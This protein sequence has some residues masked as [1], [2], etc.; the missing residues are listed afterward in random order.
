QRVVGFL[1]RCRR[2]SSRAHPLVSSHVVFEQTLG[3]INTASFQR[4]GQAPVDLLYLRA[5]ERGQQRAPN[6][7]VIELNAK[8]RTAAA[9][10]LGHSKF[11]LV[12]IGACF[13]KEL[14]QEW[15]RFDVFGAKTRQ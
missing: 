11:S 15:L 9:Q 7:I 2:M 12:F 6:A 3:I 4:L 8:L 5:I 1:C 10:E 13:A 14:L